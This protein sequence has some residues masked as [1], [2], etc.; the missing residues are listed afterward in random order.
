[1]IFD[2][3]EARV[4]A[5]DALQAE[6]GRSRRCF[7]DRLARRALR[8]EQKSAADAYRL[9]DEGAEKKAAAAEEMKQRRARARS[10]GAAKARRRA[11][12]RARRTE[13]RRTKSQGDG[14]GV[15]GRPATEALTS[16]EKVALASWEHQAAQIAAEQEA[17]AS[18]MKKRGDELAAREARAA[19]APTRVARPEL[20]R[21]DLPTPDESDLVEPGEMTNAE[22]HRETAKERLELM[23]RGRP[24]RKAAPLSEVLE[25]EIKR[26]PIRADLLGDAAPAPAARRKKKEPSPL[27]LLGDGDLS[28]N[29]PAKPQIRLPKINGATQ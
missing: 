2:A 5:V 14:G 7:Q 4:G 26:A 23:K 8:A 18:R 6:H 9:A 28:L 12:G 20:F 27:S 1:M 15:R 16:E 17:V 3:A 21:L 24:Q 22:W 13:E 29:V 11:R 10:E 25:N 19:A